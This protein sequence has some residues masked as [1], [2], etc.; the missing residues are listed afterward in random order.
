MLHSIIYFLLKNERVF[1]YKKSL[2]SAPVREQIKETK[3]KQY[4][5]VPLFLAVHT[6]SFT[7]NN[8]FLG[9]GRTRSNLLRHWNAGSADSSGMTGPF[10]AFE[11]Y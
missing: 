7:S 9:N 10:I 5:A 8:V 3:C 1:G 2:L 11:K 6:H 4:S